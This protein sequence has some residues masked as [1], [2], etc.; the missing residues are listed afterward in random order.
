M[1]KNIADDLANA[2]VSISKIVE[3]FK[4]LAA[5]KSTSGSLGSG[6]VNAFHVP[7]GVPGPSRPQAA[8]SPAPT[9][10]NPDAPLILPRNQTL[11][12]DILKKGPEKPKTSVQVRQNQIP[13]TQY[14]PKPKKTTFMK[15]GRPLRLR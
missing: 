13:Q 11:M 6:P 2:S 10:V 5:N 15:E 4:E 1:I 14:I 8:G 9:P 12:A 7:A 3:E